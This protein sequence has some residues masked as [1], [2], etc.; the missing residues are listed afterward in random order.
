M[1]N[2]SP[3][4][5]TPPRAAEWVARA[6]A[7]LL[8]A[9][10]A[11]TADNALAQPK[12]ND[13]PKLRFEQDLRGD[14]A[15]IG[16]TLAQDCRPGATPRPIIGRM[17]PLGG[18]PYP[19]GD[20]VCSKRDTSPDFF[21][22][23]NDWTLDTSGAATQPSP[24]ASSV[25][26]NPLNA[27]T[28]AALVLPTGAKI[29]YAR[30]YWAAT[31]TTRNSGD[32][33]QQP[34][35]TARLSRPGV[36]GFEA[37]L[38]ADDYAFQVDAPASPTQDYQYQY[39]STADITNIVR[40]YGA[41]RYQV[42][43]V[44][45][46]NLDTTQG[47]G[48]YI[49]DAWWMAV[50]YEVPGETKRHLKLF[51]SMRVVAGGA[52]TSTGFTLK[53][54]YVPSYAVDAKL[55]VVAFEGDDPAPDHGDSLV[56][57]GR[58]L[59]ND[60]NPEDNFFNSTRSW[61]TKHG[62]IAT[63]TPLSLANPGSDNVFD[64]YPISHR[65]DRPQLT[66]TPGSMS[67]IDLDVV[68]VTLAPG[69]RTASAAATSTGDR[70]WLAGFITSITT[71]APD[72]V[73]TIKSARNVTRDDGTFR[74]NDI[75]EYTISTEN[76]GDDTSRDTVLN[77]K[78]PAQ[79]EYVADSLRLLSVAA[80][81]PR[82]TG[83]LTDAKGDDVGHYDAATGTLTVYLGTG[84]TPTKGGQ[85]KGVIR[86]GDVAE[87]TSISFRARIRSDAPNGKVENQGI[88]TAGGVLGIDPV[89]TPSRNPDGKGPT[90]IEVAIVPRPVIQAPAEGAHVPTDKPTYSG[91]A[92][93]GTTVT[94]KEGNT[95]L[96]TATTT[97]AGTWSC[98]SSTLPQGGHTVT[99]V[100]SNG[101]G[102]SDP[103]A[104]RSFQ[105]DTAAPAAP[106]I[107]NPTANAELTTQ[108]PTFEGTAEPN[109]LVIVSVDGQVVGRTY[110]DSSGKWW[111]PSNLLADGP[112]TVSA[113]S[114][115]AAGNRSSATAVPFTIKAGPPDTQIDTK[116]PAKDTSSTAPFS[117]TGIV[118][119]GGTSDINGFDCSLNGA[120][121]VRCS[122][123]SS[124]KGSYTYTSLPEG[125][126]TF[127][128]RARNN[129][130][131]VDLSPAQWIWTIGLDTDN[132]GI[133]DSI[134]D[135]NGNGVVDPGETDPR[136]PD[137][138]G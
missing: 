112:H 19:P 131:A 72:F 44:Q 93:P 138:D 36:A 71:Q 45:A 18:P 2:P 110:A 85:L 92:L 83:P 5:P 64:A 70:Y 22:T 47:G 111:V 11:L 113:V 120:T 79:L 116:P 63:D 53:G 82:G 99:A 122:N 59:S 4:L 52:N 90:N 32:Q 84:A 127:R 16:T 42:S 115:D 128:V 41:G 3:P 98:V 137:T 87:R 66:G 56:F 51:D 117:F 89:D 26:I 76:I 7:M 118:P 78:L 132:D 20:P 17:P 100:A 123:A 46:T 40:Q 96:C 106:V 24:P 103:S 136:N 6:T 124:R 130:G 125:R 73:N 126:Y 105:V 1:R 50:F 109:S 8:T 28:R 43:D 104:P 133:P 9:I 91:T 97:P 34:D 60:L 107:T 69:D 54:F 68:D 121:F 95:V 62:P 55:G 114:Q 81:D 10:L 58:K 49:F 38:T 37:S 88:I 35:L 39:Q 23:L 65:N 94:V 129:A 27:Q 48:E 119:S 30:L 61:T 102:T 57:N 31:R 86:P 21:W 74:P 80:S 15:L 14:F 33:I 25:G 12:N 108:R 29:V 77:D 75:I 135:K 13:P 134:E 101:E 67:G